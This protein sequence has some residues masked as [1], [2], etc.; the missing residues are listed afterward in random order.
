MENRDGRQNPVGG[1]N[2]A[3]SPSEGISPQRVAERDEYEEERAELES[4]P[5]PEEDD[6]GDDDDADEETGSAR[7]I[8]SLSASFDYSPA[9]HGNVF[10]AQPPGPFVDGL[11]LPACD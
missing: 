1:Q 4:D 9:R 5:S 2:A 11:E 10:H 3:P 7:S 6:I 8:A